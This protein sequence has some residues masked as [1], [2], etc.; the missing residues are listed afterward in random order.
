MNSYKISSFTSDEEKAWLADYEHD[1]ELEASNKQVNDGEY[2]F[3]LNPGSIDPQTIVMI[4]DL[5]YEDKLRFIKMCFK[6]ECISNVSIISN[7]VVLAQ[8]RLIDEELYDND[9]IFFVDDIEFLDICTEL[10][11]EIKNFNSKIVTYF[12]GA[13][14]SI[15]NIVDDSSV[16]VPNLYFNAL[17]SYNINSM[18]SAMQKADI[19]WE[20]VPYVFVGD[21]IVE[22]VCTG[23]VVANKILSELFENINLE[24]T[25]K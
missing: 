2:K 7:L 17:A 21:E 13:F 14:K 3:Q 22:R 15:T 4:K 24:E 10:R 9:D 18:S 6:A 25:E 16:H 5:P 23:Q 8:G 11:T 12:L 19:K 20:D 1:V